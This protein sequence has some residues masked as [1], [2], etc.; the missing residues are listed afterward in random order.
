MPS[1]IQSSS[2]VTIHTVN[3]SVQF[4]GKLIDTHVTLFGSLVACKIKTRHSTV[5]INA[6]HIIS[7]TYHDKS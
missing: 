5:I 7:I 2:V 6:D 4:T 3:P 1:N